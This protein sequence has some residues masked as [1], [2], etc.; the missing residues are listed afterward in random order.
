[1]L[2]DLILSVFSGWQTGS[3]TSTDNAGVESVRWTGACSVVPQSQDQVTAHDCSD[4]CGIH[5]LLDTLSGARQCQP[6]GSLKVYNGYIPSSASKAIFNYHSI[7]SKF[8][9]GNYVPEHVNPPIKIT[10]G[11]PVGGEINVRYLWLNFFLDWIP[12]NLVN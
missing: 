4:C 5:R 2:E 10:V 6:S 1:L 11:D 7:D 3:A 12:S 8:G 9:V